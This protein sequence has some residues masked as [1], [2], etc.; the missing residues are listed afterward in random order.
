ML[1]SQ[2]RILQWTFC[3]LFIVILFFVSSYQIRFSLLLKL[4]PKFATLVE[5]IGETHPSKTPSIMKFLKSWK[6]N[7]IIKYFTLLEYSTCAKAYFVLH[8]SFK[9]IYLSLPKIVSP[10]ATIMSLENC[11]YIPVYVK[12]KNRAFV[13]VCSTIYALCHQGLIVSVRN[14]YLNILGCSDV[15][16]CHVT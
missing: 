5:L 12:M 3:L 7:K 2:W 15:I 13:Y 10:F 16:Q 14:I 9:I 11:V 8:I 4:E 1:M 6:L